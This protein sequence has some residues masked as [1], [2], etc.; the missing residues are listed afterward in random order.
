[1]K[2]T[3]EERISNYVCGLSG[4]FSARDVSKK[5]NLTS[6]EVAKYFSTIVSVKVSNQRNTNIHKKVT[7][8]YSYQPRGER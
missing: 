8:I 7:G 3:T 4:D 1:M 2:P 6:R 5:L